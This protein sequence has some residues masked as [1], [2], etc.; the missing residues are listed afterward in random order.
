MD[1][2]Q[3]ELRSAGD[4][5]L[6]AE[7]RADG[8]LLALRRPSD[9]HMHLSA[10]WAAEAEAL[11]LRGRPRHPGTAGGG[12]GSGGGQQ[13]QPG[14]SSSPDGRE[15]E[16]LVQLCIDHIVECAEND[17][18]LSTAVDARAR[19]DELSRPVAALSARAPWQHSE[20]AT[21]RE[22]AQ[23]AVSSIRA[24]ADAL[25][26]Q[27]DRL[28]RGEAPGGPGGEPPTRRQEADGPAIEGR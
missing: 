23:R 12:G 10:K 24:L 3:E 5:A 27:A 14:A 2:V 18:L 21:N 6:M 7:A 13:Q 11:Y 9:E 16:L 1:D 26:R 17:A 28:E 4:R 19:I 20:R 15:K 8:L 25:A 22:E